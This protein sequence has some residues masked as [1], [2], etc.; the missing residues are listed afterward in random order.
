M[1]D[2]R[3]AAFWRATLALCLGSFTIFSNVYVTQPLLPTLAEH[4]HV[5]PLMAG[6]SFTVTTLMLGLSLLVYGPLSDA[7]GRRPLMIFTMGAA[8]LVTVAI[9]FVESFHALLILRA[10]QGFF[11]GGLPAIAIAYMGDEFTKRAL[12]IAVGYYISGNSLGGIGGRLIG[13]FMGDIAGWQSA[14]VFI[15]IMSVV[16]LI[17][18]ALALPK[19]QHFTA[20]P[21]HPKQMLRDLSGHLKNPALLIAF[22]IGGFNFFI[23]INQY[24]YVTF[25][26]ADDPYNL[27]ASLLGLL[28]LT[29]LS[30]TFGSAISGKVAQKIPQ[31]LCMAL[32]ISIL[33]LGSLVTLLP[34][35]PSIIIGLL[36]N[37]FGFFFAHSPSSS[38][39]SHK[40]QGARAS[41]SSLY[42]L[43]YYTG[44]STGGFYLHIWWD[45]WR[46]QGVVAGSLLVLTGTLLLSLKLRHYHQPEE[47]NHVSGEQQTA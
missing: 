43:F 6:W 44:A 39:V 10:L 1:I 24:S 16:L 36:I 23:F 8:T 46:W 45:A 38:W 15:A 9:C 27:P 26:L 11:L 14:F 20:K 18:F 17:V 12:V 41:A 25:V 28:F 33:M 42:L 21:L 37:S 40:A 34:G 19:S 4:F 32:G 13:G 2:I 3:S 7:V 35:L 22:I 31:P 29:Y 5:S 30:G 47:H